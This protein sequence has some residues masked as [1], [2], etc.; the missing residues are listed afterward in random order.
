MSFTTAVKTVLGKYADFQ[1][2]ASRSEF[3]WFYLFTVLVNLVFYIP[4]VIFMFLGASLSSEGSANAF[5]MILMWL[6]LVLTIAVNLALLLPT[7]AVGVRRLH[8]RAQSGWL[9]L[10]WVVPCGNI[11]LLVLWL[12]DGTPG[13]NQYGPRAS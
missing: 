7:I 9:M 6:F 3:W 11:A 8:D 13:D 5:V 10:L 4:F 12:L 1:G 2:R